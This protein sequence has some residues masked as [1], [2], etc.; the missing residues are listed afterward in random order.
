M[1]TYTSIF[2]FFALNWLQLTLLT[3]RWVLKIKSKILV[4]EASPRVDVGHTRLLELSLTVRQNGRKFN[5]LGNRDKRGGERWRESESERERGRVRV[6][7]RE[8]G[9]SEREGGRERE[10]ERG[11]ERRRNLLPYHVLLQEHVDISSQQAARTT[12]HRPL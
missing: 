7:E 10:R 11:R 12:H 3:S 9:R 4:T 6:R 1:H 8:R 5:I 2:F